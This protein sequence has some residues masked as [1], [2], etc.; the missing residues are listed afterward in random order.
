MGAGQ[1]IVR[2]TEEVELEG[3]TQLVMEWCSMG[4]VRGWLDAFGPLDDAAAQCVTAQ[5]GSALRYLRLN[6]SV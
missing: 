1:N 4:S 3:E 2:F 6:G 5:T